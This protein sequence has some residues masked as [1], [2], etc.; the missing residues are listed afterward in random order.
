MFHDARWLVLLVPFLTLA[1]CNEAEPEAMQID[2]TQAMEGQVDGHVHAA[3]GSAAHDELPLRAI[4]QQLAVDLAGFTH[5]LLLEDFETMTARSGAIAEHAHI[6]PDDVRRIE[7]ELG[8]EMA[9]F[10]AADEAVHLTAERLHQ[11]AE[12]RDFNA[13]LTRLDE[14]HR[15]CV[16]CHTQFRE[17]LR[18]D[19]ATSATQR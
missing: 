11:A 16:A 5:A 17:R 19:L 7:A 10:E 15:G 6:A 18:T 1:A 4:M 9:M 3:E 8:D 2:G 12:A 13:I 14:I